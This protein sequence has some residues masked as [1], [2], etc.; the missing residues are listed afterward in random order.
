MA[1]GVTSIGGV[2]IFST[3][4]EATNII[5][6]IEEERG[7]PFNFY[8]RYYVNYIVTNLKESGVWDKSK[9]IYG[10]VGGTAAAHK[11]NW[12]DM[13]DLDAAFRLT[14]PSG[15]VSSKLY[16]AE[17]NGTSHYADTFLIPTTSFSDSG[18]NISLGVHITGGTFGGSANPITM[19]S[20]ISPP[21]SNSTILTVQSTQI[22][23][24]IEGESE[25]TFIVKSNTSSTDYF[26]NSGYGGYHRLFKNGIKLDEKTLGAKFGSNQKIAIGAIRS[27]S[28]VS[29]FQNIKLGLV[30]VSDGLTEQQVFKETQIF[31]FGQKMRVN[32]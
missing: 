31:R 3:D 8:E 4:P 32:F 15:I 10:M 7:T 27:A 19:G 22:V 5:K 24:E 9:A 20:I 1:G 17:F 2:T 13:R 16:G 30:K 6:I 12:K 29:L 25:N 23:S 21:I 28:G 26:S 14:F 11:W 18:R